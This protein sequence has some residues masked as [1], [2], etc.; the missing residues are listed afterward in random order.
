MEHWE[1]SEQVA[2]PGGGALDPLKHCR[3]YNVTIIPLNH[4]NASTLYKHMLHQLA[5]IYFII[6]LHLLEGTTSVM[7]LPATNLG[8]Y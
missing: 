5:L 4:L 8:N 2:H 6:Y 3:P 1:K 7:A